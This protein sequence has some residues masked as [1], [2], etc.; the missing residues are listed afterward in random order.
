MIS[1]KP[2]VEKLGGRGPMKRS[3]SRLD[4]R[5]AQVQRQIDERAKRKLLEKCVCTKLSFFVS[6]EPEKLEKEMNV[7]CPAHESRSLGFVFSVLVQPDGPERE[8]L[9]ARFE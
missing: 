6:I 9:N 8:A 2:S 4:K 1:Y 3:I 7:P 5:L